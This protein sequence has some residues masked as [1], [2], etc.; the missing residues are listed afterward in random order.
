ML[1]PSGKKLEQMIALSMKEQAPQMYKDLTKAGTLQTFLEEYAVEMEES[2]RTAYH[3]A[4]TKISKIHDSMQQVQEMEQAQ[5]EIWEVT[6]AD[7]L[8][9]SDPMPPEIYESQMAA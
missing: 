2:Y 7:Y 5:R 6:R 9:F 3:Q 4:L 1:I 8:E